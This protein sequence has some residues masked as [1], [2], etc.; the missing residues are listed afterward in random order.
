MNEFVSDW[1]SLI[2]TFVK[3]SNEK[4]KVEIA[5]YGMISRCMVCSATFQIKYD[6]RNHW[7]KEPK[8]KLGFVTFH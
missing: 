3:L 6:F 1:F 7:F 2:K 4:W 8:E 5:F